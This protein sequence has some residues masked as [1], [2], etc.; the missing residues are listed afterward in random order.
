M[1]AFYLYS[2]FFI[3]PTYSQKIQLISYYIPFIN[4]FDFSKKQ[5]KKIL[6]LRFYS[7]NIQH[8]IEYG[9]C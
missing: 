6:T 4:L 2:L 1:S 9:L 7:A 8:V 3:F 5:I